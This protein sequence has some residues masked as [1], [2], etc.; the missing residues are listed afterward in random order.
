[1]EDKVS[2]RKIEQEP[3]DKLIDKALKKWL[4]DER[5][6]N[7]VE[8]Y[9]DSTRYAWAMDQLHAFEQPTPESGDRGSGG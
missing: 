5:A 1:V 8:R 4:T 3:R 2:A 9:F 6:A 7:D